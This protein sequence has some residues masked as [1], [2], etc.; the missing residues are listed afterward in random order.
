MIAVVISQKRLGIL[1]LNPGSF[2]SI[3]VCFLFSPPISSVKHSKFFLKKGE[4]SS[5]SRT[6]VLLKEERETAVW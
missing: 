2:L 3:P 4:R 1:N 5:F 6:T